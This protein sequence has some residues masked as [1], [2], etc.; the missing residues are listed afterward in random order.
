MDVVG[1][2]LSKNFCGDKNS[3]PGD[4]VDLFWP[5]RDKQLVKDLGCALGFFDRLGFGSPRTPIGRWRLAMPEGS[6]LSSAV[7]TSGAPT[8][9]MTQVATIFAARV[10]R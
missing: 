1:I 4:L 2:L 8:T 9:K 3:R 6:E 10:A 5:S 7:M